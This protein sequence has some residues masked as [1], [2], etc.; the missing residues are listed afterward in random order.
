MAGRL[1][2]RVYG[3]PRWRR[4]RLVVLEAAGYSCASCGSWAGEVHHKKSVDDGGAWF[5]PANLIAICTDCHF[6]AHHKKRPVM[7]R[8]IRDRAGWR[9]LL[10]SVTT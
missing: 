4:L 6:R 1:A 10:A 8:T 5:D 2:R 3:S 7:Q 9:R